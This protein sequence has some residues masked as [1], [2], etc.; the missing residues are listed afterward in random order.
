VVT[1]AGCLLLVALSALIAMR[2]SGGG[3]GNDSGMDADAD[4][5][6]ESD[7]GTDSGP[8]SGTDTDADTDTG[9]GPG[10]TAVQV[11]A[12]GRHTCALIDGGYLKPSWP[13]H[14]HPRA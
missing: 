4:S 13:F 14:D 6:S 5:D 9:T 11:T 8:D 10:D 7:A 2:C 12:G 3:G 1:R